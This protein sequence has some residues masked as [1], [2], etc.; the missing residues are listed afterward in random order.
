MNYITFIMDDFWLTLCILGFLTVYLTIT[1]QLCCTY[2]DDYKNRRF[3]F[4]GEFNRY[5]K[6]HIDLIEYIVFPVYALVA[7]GVFVYDRIEGVKNNEKI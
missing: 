4:N 1:F 7:F 5:S 6:M 3:T 2:I